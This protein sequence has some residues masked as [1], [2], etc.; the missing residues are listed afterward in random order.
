MYPG[1]VILMNLLTI[2]SNFFFQNIASN[3]LN[4]MKEIWRTH[5][6]CKG[7]ESL[8][9]KVNEKNFEIFSPHKKLPL[10]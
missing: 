1:K 7:K 10:N 8:K 9:W 2:Q 5:L 3:A 6:Q 4:H